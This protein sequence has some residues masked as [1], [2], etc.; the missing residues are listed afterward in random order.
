MSYPPTSPTPPINPHHPLA[1]FAAPL[2]PAETTPVSSPLGELGPSSSQGHGNSASV[3]PAAYMS[4]HG[5]PTPGP[6]S[7]SVIRSPGRNTSAGSLGLDKP[8][9]GQG[10][11]D[12]EEE[13]ERQKMSRWR[14][15][16]D[17]DLTG[18]RGGHGQP[19]SSYPR[20]AIPAH[21]YYYTPITGTIGKH[22]PKEI[23]RIERDWSGGEVCQFETTFP[24]EL[25]GRIQ[26]AQFAQFIHELNAIL[27]CAYSV[28]GAVWDNLLAVAS[29]WTSLLWRQSCFERELR[30]AERH[31]DESNQQLFN[32]HG[33]NVLSP[34]DVALQFLEIE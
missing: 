6:S 9:S 34:R 17:K 12:W 27:V 26:P 18:W 31:I 25:D 33:L 10:F 16:V 11:Q 23:V 4:D 7:F 14:D 21:S 20:Q 8:S 22:L 32:A 15:K 5:Y 28:R 24:L 3:G 2:S 13:Y 29:L 30:R 1:P 19:R